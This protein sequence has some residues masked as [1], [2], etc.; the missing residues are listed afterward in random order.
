ER[1]PVDA[2]LG[3][4]CLGLGTVFIAVDAEQDEGPALHPLDQLVLRG[5]QANARAA[6]RSPKSYDHDFAAELGELQRMAVQVLALDVG[7]G[8]ADLE[9]AEPEQRSLGLLAQRRQL[10]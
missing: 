2:L 4:D 9:V 5:D 6:P 3:R 1:S 10:R 8:A 7:Q